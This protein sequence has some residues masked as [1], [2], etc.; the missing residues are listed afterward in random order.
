MR[1]WHVAQL[2]L[3]VLA[4][5]RS[6]PSAAFVLTVDRIHDFFPTAAEWGSPQIA[7]LYA[8]PH[9]IRIGFASGKRF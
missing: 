6:H 5:R 3:A 7:L 8:T 2:T 1:L 9:R 4:I